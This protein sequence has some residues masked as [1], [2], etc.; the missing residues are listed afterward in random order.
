M[1]FYPY[2][3]RWE[4]SG[5]D[6]IPR[7]EIPSLVLTSDYDYLAN[8]VRVNGR[9]SHPPGFAEGGF[10]LLQP[11]RILS[12]EQKNCGAGIRT[13][14]FE[15][16]G[17]TYV[18]TVVRGLFS[19]EDTPLSMNLP[20]PVLG[21]SKSQA[22]IVELLKVWFYSAH[23]ATVN[24]SMMAFISTRPVTAN[25]AAVIDPATLA[26]MVQLVHKDGTDGI[27]QQTYPVEVNLTDEAGHGVLVA[28]DKIYLTVHSEN[29]GDTNDV[30][31]KMLYRY[32]TVGISEYVGIV[33][34][35]G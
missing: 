8:G 23:N 19:D 5:F 9:L 33:Q 3:T 20:K 29:T 25:F 2:G 35:Q 18:Y 15:H 4:F 12:H 26:S 1:Q 16:S 10:G 13:I 11:Q 31:V 24:S 27:L 32:K 28:T 21:T 22:T 17:I 7:E 14:G 34:S 30:G 6:G